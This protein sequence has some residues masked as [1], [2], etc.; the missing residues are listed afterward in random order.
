LSRS[1]RQADEPVE[2][3]IYPSAGNLEDVPPDLPPPSPEALAGL[4]VGGVFN[5]D[6]FVFVPQRA[7]PG[8]WKV[9]IQLG[10]WTS[11]EVTVE[12]VAGK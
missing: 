8:T 1:R 2:G 9:S 3:V 12:L 7:V 11:N 6:A 5:H 10:K 4:V